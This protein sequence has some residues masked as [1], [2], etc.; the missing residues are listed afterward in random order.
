MI[1]EQT[2]KPVSPREFILSKGPSSL[3][4]RLLAMTGFERIIFTLEIKESLKIKSFYLIVDSFFIENH[5][6]L[7][8]GFDTPQSLFFAL[9]DLSDRIKVSHQGV[10]TFEL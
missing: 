3:L 5:I 10:V 2:L 9:K 4:V 8:K 7:R 6:D 1:C